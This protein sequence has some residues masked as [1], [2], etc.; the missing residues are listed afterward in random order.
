MIITTTTITTTMTMK[1]MLMI[2]TTIMIHITDCRKDVC[3]TKGAGNF[4][5]CPLC[6][7]LCD[8]EKLSDSCL[9]ARLT[10]VFDNYATVFFAIFMAGWGE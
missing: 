7:N 2:T 5:L 9:Y 4:T 6:D 1:A 8:F 10:H 3:N